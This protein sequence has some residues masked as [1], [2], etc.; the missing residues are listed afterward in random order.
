MLPGKMLVWVLFQGLLLLHLR[1]E[2]LIL[3]QVNLVL[4]LLGR[5]EVF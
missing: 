1:E 2:R 5:Q 4:R 3:G